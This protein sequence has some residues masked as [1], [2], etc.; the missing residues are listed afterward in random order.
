MEGEIG[1]MSNLRIRSFEPTSILPEQKRMTYCLCSSVE[2]LSR[3]VAERN[4]H[5]TGMPTMSVF[6]Y[7]ESSKQHNRFL[8][9]IASNGYHRRTVFETKT[10]LGSIKCWTCN[11]STHSSWTCRTPPHPP[12]RS[13][14]QPNT[15]L[16]TLAWRRAAAHMRQG[17]TVTY[18]VVSLKS[19]CCWATLLFDRLACLGGSNWAI[20]S[21]S[22][23]KV[24]CLL[25]SI[26]LLR[27]ANGDLRYVVRSS[28]CDR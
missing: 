9:S 16:P 23:C 25:S 27:N 6:S 28:C 7:I 8:S 26:H 24:A 3:L 4:G 21:N 10:N 15:T 17:S 11:S 22:A 19:N 13:L 12:K 14:A 18:S 1:G 5:K 20:A 2:V